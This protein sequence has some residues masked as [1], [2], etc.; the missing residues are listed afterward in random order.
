MYDERSFYSMDR[1]IEFG[2]GMAVA[3]QMT[4]TM[5]E[6]M[7]NMHIPGAGNPMPRPAQNPQTYY[8]AIDGK[9]AGPFT[10]TEVARLIADHKLTKDSLVWHPGL[11]VWKNAQDVPEILRLVALTPPP[12]PGN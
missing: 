6:T 4:K 1:L 10:E 12:V 11:P 9:Q 7:A 8:V 2:M 5:N 3:Q